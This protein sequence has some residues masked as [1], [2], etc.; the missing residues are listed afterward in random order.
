MSLNIVF[1][2][3]MVFAHTQTN[4]KR[5]HKATEITSTN[6]LNAASFAAREHTHTRNKVHS[7]IQTNV[8]IVT[9]TSSV[10]YF[11]SQVKMVWCICFRLEDRSQFG[12]GAG[13]G[14]LGSTG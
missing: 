13:F 3:M 12:S 4:R 14:M 8:F 2:F 9:V 11:M 6:I 7:N 5:N 10:L 1:L